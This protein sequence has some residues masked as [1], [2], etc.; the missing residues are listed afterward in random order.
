MEDEKITRRGFLRSSVVGVSGIFLGGG[1]LSAVA[2]Q[3]NRQQPNIVVI[4][5]DDQGYADSSCYEHPKEVD[6]PNI[7]RLAEEGVRFTNGYASGYVCAPTR[8]GLMTGRYQQRF[9]FYTAPDSRIGM[10]LKEITVADL[11][12]KE[13]Y[14]TAVIGKWHLGIEPEYHPMKRGFDEFYGF[15]GHGAHDYFKLGITD[16]YTSIYRNE[17]PIND[18]GYLTNNLAREAVSFIER[19]K[20]QPFFLYLPFNAVHWP[21]QALQKHIDRFNTGDPN[22][23]IY[24]AMLVCMDEAIGR[25]FG[26]LKR[27]G[28]DDNT[29]IFF[30]SDNGGARKNLANNGALRDYK[31]SVYEG[32]IRVPFIVR[33]PQKLLKPKVCD[34]PV[35]SLD[36]MPTICAA[37]GVKLPDDRVYD[38]KNMLPV[39]RGQSKKPLH[40]ALF[41]YDGT[42]QWAVRAGK[43]KLLSQK[44][45]LELYDLSADISEKN[46]LSK[47]NPHI[48]KR[49]QQTY[50]AW[51]G[52]LAPQI[53]RARSDR[54]AARKKK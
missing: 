2:K 37:V 51:K 10:P 16:E 32:G 14:A 48:V 46:D 52:Q 12:K 47:E 4:V 38:G 50:A 45:S 22:R 27:T 7:D 19:H 25:V 42:D 40:E 11:L 26:A 30:F 44:G 18:T 43:W 28:A 8:A 41:W 5:S 54:A 13:G 29:L 15:L 3:G 6:T 24:L 34:E 23:D 36:V 31:H 9:G 17:K 1:I 53:K 35:I 21:L 39:L 20:N 49:L 33:W